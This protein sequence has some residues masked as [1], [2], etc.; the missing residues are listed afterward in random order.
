MYK[1][2]GLRQF[3]GCPCIDGR[4]PVLQQPVAVGAP[5][6]VSAPPPPPQI[7]SAAGPI[8]PGGP[9][10]PPPLPPSANGP[11]LP[12]TANGPPLPPSATGPAVAIPGHGLPQIHPSKFQAS[13]N[14]FAR[15]SRA[16]YASSKQ[17]D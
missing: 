2:E 16:A 17:K 5:G 3:N 6:P 8:G 12:P 7:P 15:L 9:G 14:M 4:G 11:P 13:T 10:G 1:I